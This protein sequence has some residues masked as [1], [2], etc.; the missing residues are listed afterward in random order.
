MVGVRCALGVDRLGGWDAEAV[1]VFWVV[2]VGVVYL[3]TGL[4][5]LA[6]FY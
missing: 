6:F 4:G 2:E 5:V 1:S 3:E